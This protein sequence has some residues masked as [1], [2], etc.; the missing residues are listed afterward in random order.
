MQETSSVM[1]HLKVS[2][3][4]VSYSSPA[5]KGNQLLDAADKLI[6]MCILGGTGFYTAYKG[7]VHS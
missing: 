5:T 2:F 7:G 3:R 1:H 6:C 4:R